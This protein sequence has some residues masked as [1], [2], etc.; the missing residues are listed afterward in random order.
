MAMRQKSF[1]E[2]ENKVNVRLA[3]TKS[4]DLTINDIN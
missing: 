4:S 2:K 3:A 1:F